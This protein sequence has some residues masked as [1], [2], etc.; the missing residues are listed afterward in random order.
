MY[1]TVLIRT[2]LYV[3]TVL[4]CD[5]L[6]SRIDMA[7]T[8]EKSKCGFKYNSLELFHSKFHQPLG[9]SELHGPK[10]WHASFW[11]T[12]GLVKSDVHVLPSLP[13]TPNWYYQWCFVTGPDSESIGLPSGYMIGVFAEKWP[14]ICTSVVTLV[15][16]LTLLRSSVSAMSSNHICWVG[17]KLNVTDFFGFSHDEYVDE[18]W[19]DHDLFHHPDWC[20][21]DDS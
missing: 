4:Y 19:R 10:W 16:K 2:V 20:H 3:P 1:C 18:H 21:V 9:K 7:S 12:M 13:Q 6:C 8:E 11:S 14:Q 17:S 15:S 5:V